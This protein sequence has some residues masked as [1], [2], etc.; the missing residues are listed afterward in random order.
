MSR[1]WLASMGAF[2]RSILFGKI[3]SIFVDLICWHLNVRRWLASMGVF[4]AQFYSENL[5]QS[6]LTWFERSLKSPFC[7]AQYI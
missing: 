3:I 5:F 6:S 2:L 1:R 4:Y 7:E